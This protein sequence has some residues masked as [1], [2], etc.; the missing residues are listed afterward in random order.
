MLVS[1]RVIIP[2]L[3][4]LECLTL[5]Y[6]MHIHIFLNIPTRDKNSVFICLPYRYNNSNSTLNFG[7]S[8]MFDYR[9]YL[10]S[11]ELFLEFRFA[12]AIAYLGKLCGF[13]RMNEGCCGRMFLGRVRVAVAID[14]SS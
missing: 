5:R 7:S 2:Y 3:L 8:T 14:D 10:R 11:H 13:S 4:S 6:I 12:G 9:N 1:W